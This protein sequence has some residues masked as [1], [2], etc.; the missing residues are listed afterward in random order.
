MYLIVNYS[1]K[2]LPITTYLDLIEGE[3]IMNLS[4]I[5]KG[6]LSDQAKNSL[7]EY[8]NSLDINDNM[9]LPSE[10]K[11]AEQLGVSRITIRNAL[12]QLSQEGIIIRKHG[13]G[14]FVNSETLKIEVN[15]SPAVEFEKIIR[16]SGYEATVKLV[17]YRITSSNAKTSSKLK[18]NEKDKII[19]V[20]KIYYAD[21][22]PAIVSI[23]RFAKI[24]VNEEIEE[25]SLKNSVFEFLLKQNGEQIEQDLIEI[26]VQLAGEN[27]KIKNYFEAEKQKPLLV[28]ESIKYNKSF[29]PVLHATEYFDTDFIKF[30]F[31]RKNSFYN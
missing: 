27:Q 3:I 30:N 25:S 8:I 29:N 28:F 16:D 22:S 11:L 24:Y 1:I 17:D 10:E 6:T 31:V 26:F 12:N 18:I 14:T 4:K 7:N 19:I 20:E 15:L 13:K 2:V 21:N 23:D 9:K 5:K